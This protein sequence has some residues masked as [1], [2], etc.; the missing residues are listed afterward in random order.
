MDFIELEPKWFKDGYKPYRVSL[1]FV[2]NLTA[3]FSQTR[4]VGIVLS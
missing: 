2:I 3:H 4:Y 1:A